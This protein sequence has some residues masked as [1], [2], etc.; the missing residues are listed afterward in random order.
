MDNELSVTRLQN[1]NLVYPLIRS[2]CPTCSIPLN[3]ILY[4][5]PSHTGDL[6]KVEV[7][8]EQGLMLSP[9]YHRLP[10][11]YKI[12]YSRAKVG[13]FIRPGNQCSC[14]NCPQNSIESNEKILEGKIIDSLPPE[15][16]S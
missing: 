5:Y 8:G 9:C 7:V 16:E 3:G 13:F 11:S 6:T 12:E 10:K 2:K 15:L 4:A 14:G 1:G